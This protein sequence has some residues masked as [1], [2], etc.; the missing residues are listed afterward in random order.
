MIEH[1]CNRM[2]VDVICVILYEGDDAARIEITSHCD[3]CDSRVIENI[4]P[5]CPFC[6]EKLG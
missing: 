6:G 3:C 1:K 2:P 4:L 5:I